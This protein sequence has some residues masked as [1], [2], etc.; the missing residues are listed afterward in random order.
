VLGLAPD[1]GRFG[2]TS[3]APNAIIGIE[4]FGEGDEQ[5]SPA[6]ALLV[7]FGW[8]GAAFAAAGALLQR[9]DLV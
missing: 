4:A 8:V 9:R 1:W 5:L 6:V 2:P 3:G 7:M